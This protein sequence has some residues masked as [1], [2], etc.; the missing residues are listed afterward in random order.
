M[1]VEPENL[2]H[3]PVLLARLHQNSESANGKFGFPVPTYHA[4]LRQDNPWTDSQENFFAYALQRSFELDQSVNGPNGEIANLW[5]GIFQSVIP[6]LFSPLE[7]QYRKLKPC[8][9]HGDLWPENFALDTATKR[10]IIYD[11]C[12]FWEHN[13]C[14]SS[15]LYPVLEKFSV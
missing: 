11:A 13:E 2:Q 4:T 15:Q 9:I 12:S 3:L 1:V 10:V 8:L 5:H 6:K 14:Q 7:N